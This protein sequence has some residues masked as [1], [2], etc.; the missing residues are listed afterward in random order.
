M[1]VSIVQLTH[2]NAD[3]VR[4]F[5]PTVAVLAERPEVGEWLVLDNG[6]N[7]ETLAAL[8]ELRSPKLRIIRSAENLGCGG[9][10][11]E[12][13]RMACGDLVL[14]LDS[15]VDVTQPEAIGRMAADL[16]RPGV[17]VVGEHGGWVRRGWSWTEEAGR[18]YAGPVPIVCGFAQLFRREEVDA[19]AHRPEYGPYWLD[20][21]EF[22]LQLGAAGWIDRYGF[23]H[24]WSFTNGRDE[25]ARRRA[26]NIFRRRWRPAGLAVHRPR[27]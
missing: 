18:D 11:N 1:N 14:S 10:R 2:N 6:S 15:D 20:D 8:D 13:W 26:W 9:G 19:W 21:S 22:C 17:R 12:L 16:A 7:A 5:M 4:R 23:G 27:S 3:Q 25:A 24:A